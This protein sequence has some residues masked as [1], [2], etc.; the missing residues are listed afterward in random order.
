MI[1]RVT[2]VRRKARGKLATE[3][4]PSANPLLSW[5]QMQA[6]LR[7]RRFRVWI[8]KTGIN[9]YQQV[10]TGININSHQHVQV[11]FII[12]DYIISCPCLRPCSC[13]CSGARAELKR[14]TSKGT[15][16]RLRW[17]SW[18]TVNSQEI[19]PWY[20][21]WHDLAIGLFEWIGSS[22][23][24]WL[25]DRAGQMYSVRS[26]MQLLQSLTRS[27]ASGFCRGVEVEH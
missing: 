22:K 9:R 16:F 20:R 7:E 18:L 1:R 3:G 17:A 26:M 6:E 24:F 14:N 27:L 8:D 2:K 10:S 25:N 4:M 19:Q 5:L 13:G 23:T 12:I 11:L 15:I 21:I